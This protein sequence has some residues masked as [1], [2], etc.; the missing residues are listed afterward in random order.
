MIK[1]P[2]GF[3]NAFRDNI[4][5]GMLGADLGYKAKAP[6]FQ[7]TLLRTMY[8]DFFLVLERAS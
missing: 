4:P 2:E 8:A 3:G 6:S 1:V 7:M 5:E